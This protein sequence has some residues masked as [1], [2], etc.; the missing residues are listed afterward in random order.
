[1]SV[2]NERV[3]ATNLR[4]ME[5]EPAQEH[6][7]TKELNRL[8]TERRTAGILGSGAMSLSVVSDPASR[9]DGPFVERR[10]PAALCR[11]PPD[12]NVVIAQTTPKRVDATKV[13]TISSPV[14]GNFVITRMLRSRPDHGMTDPH[15]RADAYVACV[16]LNELN[17]YDVWCNSQHN[18]SRPL[19]AGTIH[20]NDM[21]E[22]WCAD[23]GS[24]FHA[25]NFYIP[26]A[27][28]D[29]YQRTR[30]RAYRRTKMSDEF[31]Q[32]DSVFKNLALALLPA[33]DKPDQMNSLFAEHATRTVRHTW[34]ELTI[35]PVAV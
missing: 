35:R 4:A 2:L 5:C 10:I 28:L 30:R 7:K 8:H 11:H 22:E 32:I 17:D 13:L 33:L 15:S 9:V 6:Y 16:H 26:Q 3:G 18:S 1:M 31:G 25:M 14:Q 20:I 12:I 24:P 29:D 19:G 34:Q 23:I 21:R 27:A